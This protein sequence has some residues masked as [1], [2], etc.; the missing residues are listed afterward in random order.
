MKWV[1]KCDGSES[2]ST[3]QGTFPSLEPIENDGLTGVKNNFSDR[4][5]VRPFRAIKEVWIRFSDARGGKRHEV[6]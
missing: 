1:G 4:F 5:R 2:R 6:E 3:P